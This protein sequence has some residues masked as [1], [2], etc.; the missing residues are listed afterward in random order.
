MNSKLLFLSSKI[1]FRNQS[2]TFTAS[3]AKFTKGND[4]TG[5]FIL[6]FPNPLDL[7]TGIEKKE[8]PLRLAGNDDP[9]NL[10]A[11]KHG[12]GTYDKPTLVPSAFGARIIGCVCEEDASY[13][14]WM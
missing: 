3:Y 13:V 7:A 8:M 14:K 5:I 11:I 12:V 2:R 6:G 4:E 9:Y 10:K 1:I